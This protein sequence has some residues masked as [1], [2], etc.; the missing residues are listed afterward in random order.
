MKLQ[1]VELLG[2]SI[3]EIGVSQRA[4]HCT[5]D[6][7][8]SQA[9]T[10]LKHEKI[11]SLVVVADGKV[12]G[13]FTERDLLEKAAFQNLDMNTL[14]VSDLMTMNPVCVQ[15]HESIGAV[16][17]RMRSGKLRHIIITDNYEH[18]E[19]VVSMREIMDYFL[20]AVS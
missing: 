4:R 19:K 17:L 18:L 9:A 6:M 13:I 15:R 16:L 5:P 8:V 11:G 7:P 3:G 20:G 1:L 14:K 10:I 12:K 2:R